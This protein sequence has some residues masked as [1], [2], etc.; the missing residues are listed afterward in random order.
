MVILAYT[1]IIV[2]Y[3]P[4]V[5]PSEPA[6]N[7]NTSVPAK[8]ADYD[9]VPPWPLIIPLYDDIHGSLEDIYDYRLIWHEAIYKFIVS[10]VC[11]FY[12]FNFQSAI[13][14]PLVVLH[15][16]TLPCQPKTFFV[17]INGH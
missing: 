5:N 12:L 13:S 9:M 16:P 4:V 15:S 10:Y 11:I 1:R 2:P 14:Y 3:P 17:S 7:A 6:V 8:F